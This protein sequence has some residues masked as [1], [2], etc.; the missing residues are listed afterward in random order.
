[1]IK[2]NIFIV[3]LS[4]LTI[5]WTKTS[6]VQAVTSCYQGNSTSAV[7]KNCDATTGTDFCVVITKNIFFQFFLINI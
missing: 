4:F 1:M 6:L 3:I 2:K 5:I 7:I